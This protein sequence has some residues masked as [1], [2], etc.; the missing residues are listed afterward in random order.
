MSV[1]L[2][3]NVNNYD[4]CIDSSIGVEKTAEMILDYIEKRTSSK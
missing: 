2:F 1:I 4:L 3:G